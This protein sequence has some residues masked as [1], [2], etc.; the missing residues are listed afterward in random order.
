MKSS[1]EELKNILA[2]SYHAYSAGIS[3]DARATVNS[4]LFHLLCIGQSGMQVP[5]LNHLRSLH[6]FMVL[7]FDVSRSE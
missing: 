7:K 2:G 6:R 1:D 5:L 3:W 4:L